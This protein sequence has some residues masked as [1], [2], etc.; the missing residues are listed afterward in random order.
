MNTIGSGVDK[1]TQGRILAFVLVNA[2]T[3][4][5]LMSVTLTGDQNRTYHFAIPIAY[6]GTYLLD[7]THQHPLTGKITVDVRESEISMVFTN[8]CL[9]AVNNVIA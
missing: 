5:Q 7:C 9:Q 6:T 1:I 2:V 3:N 4:L 8:P